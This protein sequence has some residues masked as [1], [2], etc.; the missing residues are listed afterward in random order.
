[1]EPLIATVP[2]W[3]GLALRVRIWDGGD[4][5]APILCLPG[6]VRTG[7]DFD[8]VAPA[9]AGGRHV[10]SLDY[11]GRGGSGRSSDITRYAPEACPRQKCRHG[12]PKTTS[13]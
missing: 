3:D 1:M 13:G 8:V 2:A 9:W 11:A 12:K 5:N 7:A 4:E 10:V 6:L